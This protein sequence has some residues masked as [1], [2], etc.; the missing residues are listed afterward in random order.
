MNVPVHLGVLLS[1]GGRT[2]QNLIDRIDEGS[3]EA[4]I[5]VVISS[6]RSAPGLERAK[7]RKI[8]ALALDRKDYPTA[9]E[10]SRAI[11]E[12]LARYPVDLV[13][14][15]GFLQLYLFPPQWQG[16]VLNIHPALLPKFGGKGYY[17]H[18][19]HEAVLRAGEKESGCTVH[20]A[21]HQYDRGTII[22]QRK[23]PVLAGDTPETLAARVFEAECAAYPEAIRI[24]AAGRRSSP[25]PTGRSP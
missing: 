15:A 12:T 14:L 10:F 3:L 18:R 25:L 6:D 22:L 1:G 16:R 5:D 7:Q 24:V 9:A 20:F 13:I 19:V 17:G 23:V 8:P 21:D 11:T 2:L 4:T